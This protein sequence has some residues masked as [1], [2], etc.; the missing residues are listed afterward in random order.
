MKQRGC[1]GFQSEVEWM[2]LKYR[3]EKIKDKRNKKFVYVIKMSKNRNKNALALAVLFALAFVTAGCASG[4]APPEEE[5][6]KT[7]GCADIDWAES[8]QQTTDGGYI[9]AGWIEIESSGA[10]SKDVW[11]VKTDSNGNKEWDKTFGG[12]DWDEARAVQQTSDGG[13][14]L[15]GWITY[16]S[17]TGSREAWLVKTDSNGNKQWD[18]TF[19]GRNWDGAYSIQQTTDGGYIIAGETNS[20]L[21]GYQ[22]EDLWL[23]KTDSNGNEQWNRTF[24]G[25]EHETAYSVQQTSDG[26]YIIAGDTASYGAGGCDVW[27]LKTD[28]NGNKQ[29]DKTFGGTRIEEARS[30]QQ[31]A[32]GGYILAGYT[33]SYGAGRCDI[34]LVK[35]DSNGNKQWDKTFGTSRNDAAEYVQQTIDGGYILCGQG[36][37]GSWYASDAWLVKTDSNGNEQWNRTFG[38]TDEDRAYSAQQTADGGY[39][40]A[41]F[42]RSYGAGSADAWLIKVKGEPTEPTETPITPEPTKPTQTPVTTPT[43]PT[44][45]PTTPAFE[46]IFAIAGLMAVAY[47]IRKRKR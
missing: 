5:W 47:L 26:G 1:L 2:G 40:L 19:G 42:T 33:A 30:V 45:T 16:S 4:T 34:W 37:R 27:L 13:Y 3:A 41:G 38:G 15:A 46:A 22:Y 6:N 20:Y 24:G 18:K 9:L 10:G 44:P 31:T 17:D 29:W 23:V 32:D 28:S 36:H 12:T 43:E 7:F 11:L 14:I 8:V 35:T 25:T 39:I 21:P